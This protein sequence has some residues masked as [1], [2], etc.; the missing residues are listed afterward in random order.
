MERR[1]RAFMFNARRCHF[2]NR[3]E[4]AQSP[5]WDRELVPAIA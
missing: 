5:R 1:G 4:A 2:F 3:S